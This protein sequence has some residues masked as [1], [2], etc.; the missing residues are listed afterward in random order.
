MA[1]IRQIVQ[2]YMPFWRWVSCIMGTHV[3]FATPVPRLVQ[4]RRAA[5]MAEEGTVGQWRGTG[6]GGGA[7]WDSE[8]DLDDG[9]DLEEVGKGKVDGLVRWRGQAVTYGA[10]R[11]KA[12]E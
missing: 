7:R 6:K 1:E 3:L 5:M 9:T 12:S 2:K 10:W 11:T 4:W 8:A